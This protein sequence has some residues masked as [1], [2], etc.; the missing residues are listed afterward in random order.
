MSKWTQIASPLPE[1]T[2]EKLK[3]NYIQDGASFDVSY[4]NGEYY[5]VPFRTSG[6]V[7]A[8]N[9]T[10][11]EQK[12]YGDRVPDTLEEL[13]ALIE[14]FLSDPDTRDYI[15]LG[16]YGGSEGTQSLVYNT[17][18]KFADIL[19]GSTKD[20]NY[21]TGRL[22]PP[23]GWNTEE[24]DQTWLNNPDVQTTADI[25]NMMAYWNSKKYFGVGVSGKNRESV[26]GEFMNGQSLMC[27]MNNNDLGVVQP[28]M[29]KLN[30]EV[31][32]FAFPAPAVLGDI[33]YVSGGFDGFCISRTTKYGKTALSFLEYLCST[34]AQQA[35]ADSEKSIMLN[36]NVTYEGETQQSLA[37]AMQSVGLYDQ[38]ADFSTGPAADNNGPLIN[39]YLNGSNYSDT[40]AKEVIKQS[41][42]N[43]YEDMQDTALNNPPVEWIPYTVEKTNDFD[44]SWIY[45]R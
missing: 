27:V 17:L 14:D 20:P 44:K 11:F 33:R 41:I 25:L 45:W 3:A 1:D 4:I 15:P 34:E 32:L 36:K 18:A 24:G 6:F 28:E 38:Y 21:K 35:F 37:Q 16:V 9:K 40:A 43:V 39:S 7:V 30:Y 2:I 26:L 13:V 29:D 31:G 22:A 19:S 42:Q 8:Y 10:L 5:N 12:G 23:D